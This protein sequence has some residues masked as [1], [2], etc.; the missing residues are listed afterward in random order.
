MAADHQDLVLRGL[1][2]KK[3]GNELMEL[4]G[5]R[6]IHPVNV[7]LG[8]FYRLPDAE[9]LRDFR[10]VLVQA[11]ADAQATVRDVAGFDIPDFEQ[12][13]T[14]VSL[15]R[16]DSYPLESGAFVT[17]E[18]DGFAVGEFFEHVA[19]EHVA[20]SH[21]LHARLHGSS[22][23]YVVG[24]LARYTL[25]HDRLTATARQ[26]AADAGLGE[27]CRNPFRSIVV[28]AVE[29]VEACQGALDIIDGWT[30]APAPFVDVPARAGVGYGASEAPRGVLV[31]RYRITD[32]GTI[33]D[34]VIVPPT[35][36]NQPSIEA[37]LR[38]F[39]ATRLHLDDAELTRQCEMAIR[40]YDPCISCATHFLDLTLD[41]G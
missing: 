20:H 31:H 28:R 5:G 4:V 17:S 39:V 8:G 30:G 24:P 29:L 21:A 11:L 33:A 14:Y 12:P 22:T 10:P 36:Q 23:P 13:Y 1:R 2:L 18:G 26:S 38:A 19:E 6:A 25:C 27:S 16:D 34:A 35:S 40:N 9:A 7:R 37:D 3:A 15:R 41:R 32:D